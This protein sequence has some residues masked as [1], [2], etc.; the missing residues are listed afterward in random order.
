MKVRGTAAHVAEKY[1]SLARDAHASGDL[2]TA[3]SYFQYA[4]HY[5]REHSHQGIDN[6]I[7]HPPRDAPSQ[8]GRIA[9]RERLG[10]LLKYYYREAA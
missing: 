9:C 7:P 1:M 4:E 2:V 8:D 6:E 10:G 3:E 5:N